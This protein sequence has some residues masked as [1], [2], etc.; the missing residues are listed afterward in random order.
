MPS[1]PLH[2]LAKRSPSWGVVGTV[3]GIGVAGGLGLVIWAAVTGRKIVL[4][5][6]NKVPMPLL[7]RAVGNNQFLRNDAA[8]A[9]LEMQK[10]AAAQ[11]VNLLAGSGFRSMA[12]QSYLYALK[13]AGKYGDAAVAFPGTSNHQGAV[14]MDV[15]DGVHTMDPAVW[16][17][18]SLFKWLAANARN[19]GWSWSEG[20]KINEPWHWIYVR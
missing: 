16:R 9:F 20:Q 11:G 3:V 7:V 2:T 18:K 12:E 4:G 17:Q 8:G 1:A 6:R 13:V 5:F 14:A 19:F 10:A 15:S